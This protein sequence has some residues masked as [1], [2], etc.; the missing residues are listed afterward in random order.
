M[1]KLKTSPDTNEETRGEDLFQDP[2]S[3]PENRKRLGYMDFKQG[4]F[5]IIK[6]TF[7]F[8]NGNQNFFRSIQQN[9]RLNSSSKLAS[10][11]RKEKSKRIQFNLNIDSI[12]RE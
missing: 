7:I 1:F 4:N 5:Y 3:Y 9:L 12:G 2:F 8:R 10:M 11:M 6:S